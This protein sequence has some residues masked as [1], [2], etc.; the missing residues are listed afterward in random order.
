MNTYQG[1]TNGRDYVFGFVLYLSFILATTIWC[2]NLIIYCILTVGQANNG[3]G[4]RT[5]VYRHVIE[6][7]VESSALYSFVLILDMA[8]EVRKE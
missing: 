3:T 8:F 7:L 2:T 6:V 4:S 1:Y 5:G